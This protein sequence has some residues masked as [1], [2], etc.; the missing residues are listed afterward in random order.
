MGKRVAAQNVKRET[1]AATHGS[2]HARWSTSMSTHVVTDPTT[3]AAAA[4]AAV[5]TGG[6]KKSVGRSSADVGIGSTGDT[7][8]AASATAD[9]FVNAQAADRPQ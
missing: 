6:A 7:T 1:T 4:I 5:D 9:G 8:G 2:T 3:T